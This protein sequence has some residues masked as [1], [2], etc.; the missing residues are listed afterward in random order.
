ME[1]KKNKQAR[2][3][4]V[5]PKRKKGEVFDTLLGFY[6]SVAVT[7]V[8]SNKIPTR[9]RWF[10]LSRW[11]TWP[12]GPLVLTPPSAAASLSDRCLSLTVLTPFCSALRPRL[13]LSSYGL[14]GNLARKPFVW[15]S[16]QSGQ[17]KPLTG[18]HPHPQKRMPPPDRAKDESFFF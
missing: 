12:L 15:V 4:V 8:N 11:L 2:T 6:A 16:H 14:V 1:E 18:A 10:I 9:E 17:R 13:S 5:S 3:W 7:S